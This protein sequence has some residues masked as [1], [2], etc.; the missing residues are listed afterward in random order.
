MLNVFTENTRDLDGSFFTTKSAN[1]K[2]PRQPPPKP[3]PPTPAELLGDR[4]TC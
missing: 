3:V 1:F 2:I 4:K